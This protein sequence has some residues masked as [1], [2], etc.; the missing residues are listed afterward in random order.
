MPF[1]C[2]FCVVEELKKI[3]CSTAGD[4]SPVIEADS[5]EQNGRSENVRIFG[6]EEKP[7]GDVL[8]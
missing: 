4:L 7:G 6:V 8:A 1:L 5:I 3:R 2:G